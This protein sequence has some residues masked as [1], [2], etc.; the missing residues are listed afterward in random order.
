[1]VDIVRR[2]PPAVGYISVW[3]SV[4]TQSA[5]V[6]VVPPKALIR[7]AGILVTQAF[8]S[9]G[10]DMITIGGSGNANRYADSTDV[11]TTGNKTLTAGSTAT[12]PASS[13]GGDTIVTAYTKGGSTP[14]TGKALVWMTYMLVPTS[15]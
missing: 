6:G 8:N 12:P 7:E 15:P 10:T 1:M 9:D 5:T 14:T 2:A 11:S 13:P 3:L 4:A